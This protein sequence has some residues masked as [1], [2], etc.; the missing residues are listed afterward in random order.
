F[1]HMAELKTKK[2]DGDVDAFLA[3]IEDEAKRED[4]RALRRI[5]AE[6]TGDEGAMWGDSI[7][8]FGSYHYRYASGREGDW[9]EVGFS[10]RKRSLTLYL[11]SG[12]EDREGLLSRLGKHSTGKACLYVN[13]LSDV[14][15]DVL[16]RL[17]QSSVDQAR[18][19]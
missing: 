18:S 1:G 9:F 12:F 15:R 11:M 17:V 4:A 2:H 14:D 10:P 6:V 13:R 5:M 7:V 19:S 3:G 8:G 16:R